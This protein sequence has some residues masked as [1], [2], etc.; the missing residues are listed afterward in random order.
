MN[1]SK[2][3]FWIK[4]K[5]KK[6]SLPP[7]L[8]SHNFNQ[9][10]IKKIRPNLLPN[11]AQFRYLKSFLTKKEKRLINI[12]LTVFFLSAIAWG[13]TWLVTNQTVVPTSGGEYSEALIGQPKYINPLFASANDIDADI[14][15]LIYSGLFKYNNTQQKLRP[16]LAADYTVSDD[17]KVY[18]IT[19][20][21]DVKWSDGEPLTADDVVYTFET[22]QDEEVGSPLI[23]SFQGTAIERTGDYS[24]R[25]TLK[26]PFAPF[27]STL[28]VGILPQHIWINIPPSGIRLAKNNLQPVGSGPWKFNKL[29]KDSSGNIQNYTLERNTLY[30]QNLPYL[31]T[32]TFK[33]FTDFT[34]AASSLKSQDISAIS[35]LP[36]DLTDKITGKNFVSYQFE[37]PQY[38]A[39]FF[40]QD[41]VLVLKDN[42]FRLALNVAID[43]N[44]IVS[45]SLH[46]KGEVINSPIL[47]GFLGYTPVT[48]SAFDP[49]KANEILNKTWTKIQPED[50]F[51]IEYETEVKAKQ[52][53]FDEIKNNTSTPAEEKEA[54]IKQMEETISTGIRQGTDTEPGMDPDQTFY[55]K[56]KNNEILTL[57]ITTV[58]SLEYVQIAEAVAKMW[59]AIGIRTNIQIIGS[60][61]ISRDILRS[62]NYEVLLYGEIVGADPD[63]YPFWHSSQVNYPGL[64]LSLFADRAADKLLEDARATTTEKIR[65]DNYKKFQDILA[66]EIPAIF[67][68]TPTY[69]FVASTD[70]KGINLKYIYSPSDRFN[71]LSNWY[72]KT[73]YQWKD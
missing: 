28:T 46:N 26:E 56:N 44:K 38:T 12:S 8:P 50:F 13:T 57:N 67:L 51:K 21:Q 33:F 69:N 48:S 71:D 53:F 68:F 64:N 54:Q 52:N 24:V 66:K 59:R 42:D 61:Q 62:R 58:D 45:E 34:Q 22:I 40:N 35:F 15:S 31:K 72:I 11:W 5:K 27:L 17:G 60:S 36:N 65:S 1:L 29:T 7:S 25:F 18:D 47:K 19:L 10:L 6:G 73:K 4:H 39:L 32:L 9:K 63:P 2:L 14:S 43:K 37:L 3:F 70:I 30:Y 16:D 55:R 23:S 41:S 20:R 49:E